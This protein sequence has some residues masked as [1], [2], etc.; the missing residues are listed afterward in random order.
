MLLLNTNDSGKLAYNEQSH[1]TTEPK[2]HG[3]T[4]VTL[5]LSAKLGAFHCLPFNLWPEKIR[6][7]VS[8]LFFFCFLFFLVCFQLVCFSILF[9]I[10]FSCCVFIYLP[11]S[12]IHSDKNGRLYLLTST[13]SFVASI[14]TTWPAGC[15]Y[16]E[17]AA[18][19][20]Q[21][22][23]HQCRIANTAPLLPASISFY[24][25]GQ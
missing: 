22:E 20:Q 9:S 24:L 12:Q 3:Q 19:G 5:S 4:V 10:V 15:L 13:F 6:S 1:W 21:H 16:I 14:K 25:R 8:T 17:A 11:D 23:S 7:C 2:N 18:A